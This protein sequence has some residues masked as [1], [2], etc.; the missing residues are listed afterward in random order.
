MQNLLQN[1]SRGIEFSVKGLADRLGLHFCE[2]PGCW[3]R[4]TIRCRIVVEDERTGHYVDE[5]NNYCGEH[6]TQNGYCSG[7]GNF[8]AGAESFDF[9]R[10][11]LC[12]NC[13]DDPD[14][15]DDAWDDECCDFGPEVP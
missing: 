6:A 10:N 5:F 4:E 9:S 2:E 12:S 7:C 3:E 8:W 1:L 13:K 11:G 15:N 14:Y